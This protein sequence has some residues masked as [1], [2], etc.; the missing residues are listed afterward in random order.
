MTL[1]DPSSSSTSYYQSVNLLAVRF[2]SFITRNDSSSRKLRASSFYSVLG[3]TESLTT[4][5]SKASTVVPMNS[6]SS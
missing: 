5:K 2:A 4:T 6:A 3:G 1:L